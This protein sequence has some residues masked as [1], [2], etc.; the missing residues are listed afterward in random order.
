MEE[1]YLALS[2]FAS[3]IKKSLISRLSVVLQGRV[4]SVIRSIP[5]RTQIVGQRKM[6]FAIGARFSVANRNF[7]WY[8]KLLLYKHLS[9]HKRS[10]GSSLSQLDH[11]IR[12]SRFLGD[13]AGAR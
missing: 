3:I 8:R 5:G 2:S 10:P 11:R 6:V 13:L 7:A 12:E 9:E 1:S 4:A